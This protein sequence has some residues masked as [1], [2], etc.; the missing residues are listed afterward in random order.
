MVSQFNVIVILVQ[1]KCIKW[2][3]ILGTKDQHIFAMA[4]N[5]HKDIKSYIIWDLQRG[6]KLLGFTDP[7]IELFFIYFFTFFW[8]FSIF[9]IILGR[10]QGFLSKRKRQKG[11]GIYEMWITKAYPWH[12]PFIASNIKMVHFL[13]YKD[14]EY[15]QNH[16]LFNHFLD[17][18]SSSNNNKINEQKNKGKHLEENYWKNF[19]HREFFY[20]SSLTKNK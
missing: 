7:N 15:I 1:H 11:R 2:C 9:R 5:K 16:S 10:I 3:Q 14:V 17:R 8:Q 19:V 13:M 18:K 4:Q 20:L 6:W 12:F